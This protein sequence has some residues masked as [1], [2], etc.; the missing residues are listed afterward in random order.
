MVRI[1]NKTIPDNKN[2]LVALTYIYGIGK[3]T[4]KKILETCSIPFHTKNLNEE[5]VDNITRAIEEKGIL[6]EEKLR[7]LVGKNIKAKI[8]MGS[9]QGR[10][11][12]R[13][14]PI[15]GQRTRHN[16]R[17]A[18]KGGIGKRKVVAVAGKKKAPSPK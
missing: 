9:Y 6:I 14:L 11:H 3:S 7:E 2:A 18:K 16:A 1:G 4:S 17:T 12:E 8:E 15:H 10:G 5:Q 13:K